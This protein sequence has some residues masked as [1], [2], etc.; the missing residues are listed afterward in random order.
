LVQ[1]PGTTAPVDVPVEDVVG[2]F[3]V[4]VDVVGA[5][6]VVGAGAVLVTVVVVELPPH[7]ASEIV[8]IAQSAS[9]GVIVEILFM[10][11]AP[12]AGACVEVTLY[13]R[14]AG[15]AE[16]QVPCRRRA[17]AWNSEAPPGSR[18]A[19]PDRCA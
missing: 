3:G 1:L 14:S 12:P 15:A 19:P 16:Q 13:A 5:L 7:A 11:R 4:V 6:V 18:P 10:C 2:G 9:I 17:I 8:A